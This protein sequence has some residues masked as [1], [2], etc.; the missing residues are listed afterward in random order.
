MKDPNADPQQDCSGEYRSHSIIGSD[1][2]PTLATIQDVI[3]HVARQAGIDTGTVAP[4]FPSAFSVYHEEPAADAADEREPTIYLIDDIRLAAYD[5]SGEELL[6][7]GI[8]VDDPRHRWNGDHWE[9]KSRHP[10][11]G[12]FPIWDFYRTEESQ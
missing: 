8:D 9:R 2:E 5:V 4:A 1:D 12:H 6:R 10:Q 11:A 3:L 7:L